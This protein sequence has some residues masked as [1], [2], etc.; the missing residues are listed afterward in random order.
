VIEL[1]QVALA[2]RGAGGQATEEVAGFRLRRP[3]ITS[4]LATT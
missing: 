3:E 2:I 1:E 4:K